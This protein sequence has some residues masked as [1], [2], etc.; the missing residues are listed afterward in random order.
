VRENI[1]NHQFRNRQFSAGNPLAN[2]LVVIVGIIVISLS[3]ALGFVVFIGIAGFMLVMAA[4]ISVRAW[5]LNKR[6]GAAKSGEQVR[7][8]GSQ[9][10]HRV[11]EGEYHEVRTRK[12]DPDSSQDL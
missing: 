5:W 2:V 1:V 3:L 10:I 12:S 4:I 8:T 7:K 9:E 6:F 11:I